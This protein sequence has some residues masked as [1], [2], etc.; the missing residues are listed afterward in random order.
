MSV[1][2]PE[3]SALW[4]ILADVS[5]SARTACTEW[6]AH[7]V[8]AHL[9]AGAKERADLI[10]ERLGGLPERATRPFAERQAPFLA[11]PDQELRTALTRETRRFETAATAPAQRA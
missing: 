4:A 1:S 11:M 2:S 8:L 9:A 3:V 5:P 6:T 7:D 10:E